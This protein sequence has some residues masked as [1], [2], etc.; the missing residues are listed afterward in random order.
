MVS[1]NLIDIK[2]NDIAKYDKEL[3]PILLKDNS[4]KQ[5]IIWATDN[6]VSRG[7][8]Y[9]PSSQ[10]KC[11]LITGNNGDV[12]KPRVRKSKE[13]QI[14]RT[15]KKAEVFTPS[16]ICNKQNNLADNRWLGLEDAFNHEVDKHWVT[17]LDPIPFPTPKGKTWQDYL[18]S[19]RLEITCGE[20][21]YLVSRYDTISGKAIAIKERIG[22]LDRKLRVLSENINDE[23]QWYKW[24][25]IAYQ[26]IYGYEWQGDNVL[27]ARENLLFTFIDYYEAEFQKEPSIGYLK[28]IA[29]IISWNIWQ[30]DGL[31]FVIPNSCHDLKSIDMFGNESS[32][33]CEGC[34][35][36]DYHKHNGI[37]C[38]IMDWNFKE[39]FEF[40]SMLND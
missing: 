2:E 16:W 29:E 12:I 26:S 39:E 1:K 4:S 27:I 36:K 13:E 8:G 7:E 24:A 9:S 6:Y 38:K 22:L 3:L 28:E 32:T 14:L 25:K 5:N 33:P 10:I 40:V 30:M 17:N 11:E 18:R 35:E 19:T 20:A 15:K 23:K 31:K 34:S 37:Y 21:P